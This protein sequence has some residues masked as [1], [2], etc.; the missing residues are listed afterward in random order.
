MIPVKITSGVRPWREMPP[1][2]CTLS[3]C[4]GFPSLP[5]AGLNNP[6]EGF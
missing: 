1:N 5:P 6:T 4:L 2:K 3:L